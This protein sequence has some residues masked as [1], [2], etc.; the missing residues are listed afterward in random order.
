MINEGRI[1]QVNT[2]T[3]YF[4]GDALGSVRQLTDATGEIM[5]ASAYDPYGV[6]TQAYGASQTSYGFTGEFT[7]P[8]GM[9]YLRARYYMPGDGRFITRDTWM[10]D[11]DSPLSL[12][13]W[14]YVE[15][16]PVNR[17][18]PTGMCWVDI[19]GTNI[20]IPDQSTV[21][22]YTN[23][24]DKNDFAKLFGITFVNQWDTNDLEAA[25]RAAILVG[26]KFMSSGVGSDPVQA[27]RQVYGIHGSQ[28]MLF[29]WNP[30][31]TM[32]KPGYCR[33]DG[34]AN[35]KD[36]SIDDPNIL[37]PLLD[38][39]RE[40]CDCLPKGGYTHGER[41]IEFASLW[42]K[43]TSHGTSIQML[44]KTNN[45][46]HELGHAFNHRAYQYP[47][48]KVASYYEIVNHEPFYLTN[49]SHGFYVDQYGTMTWVQSTQTSGSE[50]FAD[51]FIGW[52]HGK[53]ANDAYGTVRKNFMNINMPSW[54]TNAV[55][56]P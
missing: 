20:W 33:P 5:Y 26:E 43:Y 28:T 51:M 15:G 29:T 48:N 22:K 18:D 23:Y 13:R 46:I 9:V 44:R 52:V 11:Y 14:M 32:C 56:K 54:I 17:V 35:G 7:D 6:T 53:W 12:N 42:P 55:G 39:T 24:P 37:I 2:T 41:S 16:N 49:R 25:R 21:C 47:E 19:L 38:G 10:G 8:S 4:L 36:Y 31:C 40:Q 1:A 30:S 3:E 45:I 50:I 34:N 27:F